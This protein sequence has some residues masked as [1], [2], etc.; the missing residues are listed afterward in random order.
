MNVMLA[1]FKYQGMSEA[2]LRATCDELAPN[3]AH[4]PG[5]FEKT[6][7]VGPGGEPLCG[8]IYKFRDRAS[9]DAYVASDLWKGVESTP[10]F[11]DFEVRVFDVMDGATAVT[12]GIPAAATAR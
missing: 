10:Q 2:E 3:F 8:G 9:I 7:L 1:T 11:S 4:I 6:W 12:G 5:C